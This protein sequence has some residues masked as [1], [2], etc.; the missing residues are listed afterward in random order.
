MT[1]SLVPEYA[2]NVVYDAGPVAVQGTPTK[3]APGDFPNGYVP[4]EAFAQHDNYLH[5]RHSNA[6]RALAHAQF[7]NWIPL[8]GPT[9]TQTERIVRFSDGIILCKSNTERPFRVYDIPGASGAEL[10]IAEFDNHPGGTF[11][12]ERLCEHTYNGNLYRI[13]VGDQQVGSS[14]R[15]IWVDAV[16]PYAV[17][18]TL[19]PST[20]FTGTLYEV[21]SAT[22]GPEGF[23]TDGY[24]Y[25]F[26]S[27]TTALR[28]TDPE[29]AWTS[30]TL[31]T[32]FGTNTVESQRKIMAIGD[33]LLFAKSTG[34]GVSLYA[35][36]N[37]G[38][39]WSTVYLNTLGASNSYLQGLAWSPIYQSVFFLNS[40]EFLVG[41]IGGVM[42]SVRTFA[43]R[44]IDF[45]YNGW[46]TQ[47]GF[48]A[49]FEDDSLI[50][51]HDAGVT[52]GRIALPSATDQVL[53]DGGRAWIERGSTWYG[54]LDVSEP[55]VL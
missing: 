51:S 26:S 53:Y 14:D 28:A 7:K 12:F 30:F 32:S 23:A 47:S 37:N 55:S 29:G 39:S 8:S 18:F 40:E 52:M 22:P 9:G 46:I 36:T 38:D 21:I 6:A 16:T 42:T 27:G 10:A 19:Q 11:E 1:I 49:Q 44:S 41:N 15:N 45:S 31:P 17:D 13:A 48:I 35:S 4:G 50:W 20:P 34:S 43:P 24:A 54:S 3:V 5:N 33:R 25:A 2:S